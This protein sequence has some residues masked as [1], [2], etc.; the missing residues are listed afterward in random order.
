MEV[1]NIFFVGT[2]ERSGEQDI[3]DSRASNHDPDDQSLEQFQMETNLSTAT[4]AGTDAT[5]L[6]L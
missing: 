6:W 2:N 3:T 1:Q 4:V 5:G